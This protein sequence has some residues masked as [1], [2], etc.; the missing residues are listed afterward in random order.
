MHV[1]RAE[2]GYIIV[3]QD[4]DGTLTPTTPTSTGRS[5]GQARLRR[6]ALARP[7]RHGGE[8]PQ[9]A[10]RPAD[11]RP[12]GRASGGRADRRRPEPAEADDHARPRH[13]VPLAD[14]LGRSIAMAVVVDGRA[15]DGETLHVPMPAGTITAK[16]VKS[17]S[18]STREQPA[19]RLRWRDHERHDAHRPG[20]T[21]TELAPTT[22]IALR[23][24]EP[25]RRPSPSAR[26]CRRASASAPSGHA[27]RLCLG[28][29]EWLI[30]AP[31]AEARALPRRP[32]GP[33][34]RTAP[35]R[36]PTARSPGRPRRP[37]RADAARHR[38]PLA[39]SR[40]CRSARAPARSSTAPRSSLVREA[41][42]FT[43]SASPSGA[44]SR[45]TSAP[46]STSPSAS[47]PPALKD[48]IHARHRH[49]PPLRHR[50]C[51]RHRCESSA[52][53]STRSNSSPRRTSSPRRLDRPGSVLTNKYAGAIPA[54][55]TTAAASS[56]TRSR[57]SPSTG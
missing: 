30:E 1:M 27:Q 46:S 24:A 49:R 12:E 8:G 32:R 52:A 45:R 18:S 48:H 55:A 41:V 14:A 35:S 51:R 9:A 17:P 2:K 36:S 47:S 29:D 56:S 13:L 44:P 15:R 38:L 19:Q 3:G 4:T 21:V 23:L 26:R 39:T 43:A 6:Q 31:E 22:R 42:V 57:P 28:P 34:G 54:S 37:G 25:R 50:R 5:A 20:V 16:V 40:R 11:R 7:P 10:R 33:R 53:S